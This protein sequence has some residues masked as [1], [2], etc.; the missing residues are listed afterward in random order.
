MNSN[1]TS[2]FAPLG[3]LFWMMLGP[4][5]LF[6]LALTTARDA[7]GWF[8]TKDILFLM[9][10]GGIIL[11]RLVEFRGGDPRTADG[12]RATNSHFNRYVVVSLLVGLGVYTVANVIGNR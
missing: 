4:A 6:L 7:D 8:A 12:E 11:G 2:G 3:R 5:F 9:V 1:S 10:L